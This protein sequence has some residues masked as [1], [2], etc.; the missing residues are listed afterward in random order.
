MFAHRGVHDY[1]D[2]RMPS[3]ATEAIPRFGISIGVGLDDL[4]AGGGGGSGAEGGGA[5]GP[6]PTTG[7]PKS[8]CGNEARGLIV[9][10]PLD[11]DPGLD[12]SGD[13]DL[14]GSGVAL[15]VPSSGI[16]G[17]S[18]LRPWKAAGGDDC[19]GAAALLAERDG[20]IPRIG[21]ARPSGGPVE[22]RTDERNGVGSVRT[23]ML[24]GLLRVLP[25]GCACACACAC[26]C[27]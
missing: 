19:A 5:G 12:G 10:R 18:N 3:P 16:V 13:I 25:V 15:S 26:V 17:V 11:R 2:T 7:S 6:R 27:R 21:T 1:Y 22:L 8:S 4:E 9:L 20:F 24:V 23:C 14:S